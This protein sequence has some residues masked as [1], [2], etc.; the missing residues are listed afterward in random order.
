MKRRWWFV[1]SVL[2]LVPWRCLH[3]AV[4]LLPR[5]ES[6]WPFLMERWTEVSGLLPDFMK[7]YPFA[8][9]I[10]EIIGHFWGGG[11]SLN[12]T[13]ID[14]LRNKEYRPVFFIKVTSSLL[15][16]RPSRGSSVSR[17][18]ATRGTEGIRLPSSP[19]SR[20]PAAPGIQPTPPALR[21]VRLHFTSCLAKETMAANLPSLNTAG[22]EVGE[23][24]RT[25]DK[26]YQ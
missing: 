7:R 19:R 24:L 12:L 15:P 6:K 3:I 2:R 22:G 21:V 9:Q 18:Q 1:Y 10:H 23:R 8:G 26:E 5:T 25:G 16:S 20:V 11:R 17:V 4:P 14:F 13:S